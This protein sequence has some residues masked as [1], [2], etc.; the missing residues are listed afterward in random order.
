MVR[1]GSWPR[2]SGCEENRFRQRFPV[3]RAHT[4]AGWL[5]V[6]ADQYGDRPL[7]LTDDTRLSYVAVAA[8]SR[9]LADG[10][11][12]LGV[13]PGDDQHLVNNGDRPAAMILVNSPVVSD[14]STS[15][16]C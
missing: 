7:V 8:E 16:A 10:L 6:C 4:L 1:P 13:R 12:T 9:R 3:W 5:D 15:H 2:T 14:F 11:A